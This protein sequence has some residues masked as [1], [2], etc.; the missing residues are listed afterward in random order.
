MKFFVLEFFLISQ[1]LNL[2]SLQLSSN[3]IMKLSALFPKFSFLILCS[4]LPSPHTYHKKFKIFKIIFF[5]LFF[6]LIYLLLYS[7][8]CLKKRKK[9]KIS[10]SLLVRGPL[11]LIFSSLIVVVELCCQN[12]YKR[13]FICLSL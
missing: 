7:N 1:I 2:C 11:L 4:P 5:L 8:L 10:K 3:H 13:I 12:L 6:F 9:K